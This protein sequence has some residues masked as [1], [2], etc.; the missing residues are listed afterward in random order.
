M[1][2]DAQRR[3][4]EAFAHMAKRDVQPAPFPLYPTP[5]RR[6]ASP[7]PTWVAAAPAVV[8]APF[9]AQSRPGPSRVPAKRPAPAPPQL[10]LGILLP[11]LLLLN[12]WYYIMVN[13]GSAT[14]PDTSW[15][16]VVLPL[17]WILTGFG[18]GS[19]VCVVAILANLYRLLRWTAR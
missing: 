18:I 7:A 4:D 14:L 2:W 13:T 16:R 9:S 8:A 1:H 17:V 15:L 10:F 6:V 19:V 5:A 11:A 3:Q 12:N